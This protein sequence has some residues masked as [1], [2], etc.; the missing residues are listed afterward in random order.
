MGTA[1]FPLSGVL[2]REKPRCQ[3]HSCCAWPGR[4]DWIW[5]EYSP[6][7]FKTGVSYKS[8]PHGSVP[9]WI[10]GRI[11]GSATGPKVSIRSFPKTTGS[12]PRRGICPGSLLLPSIQVSH[13]QTQQV[14][15]GK[16][17][18]SGMRQA[19][20][21]NFSA[22]DP[23]RPRG[24][25][26]LPAPSTGFQHNP[27]SRHHHWVTPERIFPAVSSDPNCQMTASSMDYPTGIIPPLSPALK[28][29]NHEVVLLGRA[30]YVSGRGGS[31]DFVRGQA[32]LAAHTRGSDIHEFSG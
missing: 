23:L 24:A 4:G 21:G 25:K 10:L 32:L 31:P 29:R 2:G 12:V 5:G 7:G 11:R 15:Q 19:E 28:G 30:G 13:S 9:N 8:N 16:E 20:V 14:P 17:S 1:S 26:L 18:A 27:S 22:S 6:N 3:P